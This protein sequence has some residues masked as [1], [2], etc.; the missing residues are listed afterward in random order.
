MAEEARVFQRDNEP[1]FFG[2]VADVFTI[3]GQ[4]TFILLQDTVGRPRSGQRLEVVRE[5]EVVSSLVVSGIEEGL[6]PRE[7]GLLALHIREM[8][9]IR[10]ER[11]MELRTLRE[12]PVPRLAEAQDVFVPR[13][14]AFVPAIGWTTLAALAVSFIFWLLFGLQVTETAAWMPGWLELIWYSITIALPIILAT[15]AAVWLTALIWLRRMRR[16]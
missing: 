12:Q 8:P 13:L 15:L 11:G 4:G 10:V 1:Q 16:T 7:G 3:T 5:T 9:D 6:R 2:K 14:A